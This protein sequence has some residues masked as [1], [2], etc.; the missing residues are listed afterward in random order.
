MTKFSDLGI[1]PKTN[2]FVGDKIPIDK[3][4]NTKISV[5]SYTI[6]DSIKKKGTKLLTL[7]IERNGIKNIIFTGS[8]VLIGMIEQVPKDKF[9]FTTTIVRDSKRLEFT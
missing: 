9:P 8:N 1:K 3:I 2:A 7:Q 5:L 4:L 6:G